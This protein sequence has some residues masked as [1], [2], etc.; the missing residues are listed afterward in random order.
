M[1]FW[2]IGTF[3]DQLHFQTILLECQKVRGVGITLCRRVIDQRLPPKGS[4]RKNLKTWLFRLLACA[5]FQ[6]AVPVEFSECETLALGHFIRSNHV[7]YKLHYIK[8]GAP[9]G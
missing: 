9:E 2:F 7:L 4:F 5:L 1:G 6:Y 8:P 3:L